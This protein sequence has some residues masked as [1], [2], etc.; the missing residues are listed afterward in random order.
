MAAAAHQPMMKTKHPPQCLLQQV[1]LR[2]LQ[3]IS[4]KQWLPSTNTPLTPKTSSLHIRQH[5][6]LVSWLF[7]PVL[8]LRVVCEVCG[9]G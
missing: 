6:F 1:R 4:A 3:A 5:W 2:Q 7:V 9:E 8:M